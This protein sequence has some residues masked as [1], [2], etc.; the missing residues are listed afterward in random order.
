[1]RT[2]LFFLATVLGSGAFQM[3]VD[4]GFFRQ[5]TWSVPW[6][7]GACFASWTVWLVSHETVKTKWFKRFHER[8][9]RGIIPIQVALGLLVLLLVGIG[10][11]HLLPAVKAST[12]TTTT[13]STQTAPP[14]VTAPAQPASQPAS[15]PD[16]KAKAQDEKTPKK[17]SGQKKK[18]EP[19]PQ[20]QAQQPQGPITTGPISTGACSNVQV[21]GSGNSLETNCAPQ[22]PN[23]R[24]ITY[25]FAGVKTV[26]E[27]GQPVQFYKYSDQDECSAFDRLTNLLNQGNWGEV[28]EI[29]DKEIQKAPQ[30]PTA[31][32]FAGIAYGNMKQT[33]KACAYLKKMSDMAGTNTQWQN[34]KDEAGKEFTCRF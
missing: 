14:P 2:F 21:G 5:F 15:Q 13:Q 22:N 6:V 11:K 23:D 30:W 9:G 12:P 19:A 16:S 31:Y 34:A 18:Q 26:V 7:W 29:A 20:P 25:T 1:M 17:A 27:P 10:L 3:T 8:V 32:M 24:V 28:A 33:E 4:A